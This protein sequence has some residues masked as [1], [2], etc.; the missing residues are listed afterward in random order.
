[1]KNSYKSLSVILA[2]VVSLS[3]CTGAVLRGGMTDEVTYQETLGNISGIEAGNGRVFIYVPKG[4]P[5]IMNTMGVI[6]FLS[7]DKDIYR[8]GGESFFYLD[9][10]A[11][12]HNATVTEVV[13]T[14][15]KLKE[16]YGQNKIEISA[17]EGDV[18]YLRIIAQK[19]RVYRLEVVPKALAESEM[20]DLP[21]WTNSATTMKIE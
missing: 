21:L 3:G 9:I 17:A 10:E 1:M 2:L 19:A 18:M 14:G 16:Q 13:K 11:G 4:G 12:S 20:A 8:F 7:I 15:F 6:D 5:D